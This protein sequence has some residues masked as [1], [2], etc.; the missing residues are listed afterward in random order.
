LLVG[1]VT[2]M[3]RIKKGHSSRMAP[4]HPLLPPTRC[5]GLAERRRDRPILNSAR[6]L[7]TAYLIFVGALV[8]NGVNDIFFLPGI[9][10]NVFFGP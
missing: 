6:T 1:E 5:L 10:H 8:I 7:Q 2:G 9:T 3:T 4:R